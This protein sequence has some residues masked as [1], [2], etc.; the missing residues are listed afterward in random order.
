MQVSVLLAIDPSTK[1]TGWAIFAAGPSTG[2]K[3]LAE[4]QS[5]SSPPASMSG[6]EAA[7]THPQWRLVETGTISTCP[8]LPRGDLAARIKAIE[9]ELDRTVETWM[10]G[11]VACGK[12]STMQLPSQQEGIEMLTRALERW[13][14]NHDLPLY[15]YPLREIRVAISGRANAAKEELAYAVMTHWDLLGAKKTTH[16]WNAIAV[17]DYHLAQHTQQT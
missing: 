3:D 5:M 17:G 1:E 7:Q 8:P 12:P 6:E 13:A 14:Q 4:R 10:P 15:S 11:E 2:S 9:A 16:E